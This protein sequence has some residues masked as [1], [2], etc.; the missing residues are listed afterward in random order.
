[1]KEVYTSCDMYVHS[2]GSLASISSY[3]GAGVCRFVNQRSWY[4]GAL[5]ISPTMCVLQW[6]EWSATCTACLRTQCERTK[7]TLSS[8]TQETIEVDSLS[9]KLITLLKSKAQFEQLHG[10]R[11]EVSQ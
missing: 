1:M 8:P 11:G 10:S 6:V 5:G 3:A 2:S 4:P 7:C 9:T